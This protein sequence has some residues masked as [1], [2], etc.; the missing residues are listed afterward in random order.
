LKGLRI[1]GYSIEFI[2]STALKYQANKCSST[3]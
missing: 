2:E 1:C 3:Q